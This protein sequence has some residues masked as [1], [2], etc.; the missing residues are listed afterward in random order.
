ML[1]LK[2][3]K[4]L[5]D[6]VSERG[7]AGLEIERAG[8]RLRIEGGRSSISNGLAEGVSAP[9]AAV[10]PAS[11]GS[12]AQPAAEAEDVHVITSPIVGTFYRAPSPEAESFAEVGSRVSKGKVLCIIE[13]M[14]L[15]NEIESDVEGEIVAVYARNGQPVEYGEKLFGIRLAA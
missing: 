1:S 3:I 12:A 6:L 13:S 11:P 2:E 8:F 5:I 4:E 14:K 7:L 9:A 15:M 10:P